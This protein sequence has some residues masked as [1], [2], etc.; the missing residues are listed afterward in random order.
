MARERGVDD[1]V[2]G[3]SGPVG[4]YYLDP[5][6]DDLRNPLR[7]VRLNQYQDHMLYPW[8]RRD[9]AVWLVVSHED[10]S[11]W[12][13]DRQA[14]RRKLETFLREQCEVVARFD[15]GWTP[16]DLDVVVYRRP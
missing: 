4:A 6:G 3:V 8:L 7:L 2:F 13:S 10:L 5:R 12:P 1:L 11:G 14:Q 15:V 9:R 16:R